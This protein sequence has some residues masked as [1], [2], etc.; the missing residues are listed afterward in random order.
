MSKFYDVFDKYAE[1]FDDV[2]PTMQFQGRSKSQLI[3][4]MEKC[5]KENKPS[6]DLYPPKDDV[7][8]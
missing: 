7:E 4:M 1:Q 5:I 8:Y 3:D 2:F 6:S